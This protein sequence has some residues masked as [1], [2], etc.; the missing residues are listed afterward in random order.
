MTNTMRAYHNDP[1]LKARL[2]AEMAGHREADRL[3]Q[4][5]YFEQ[6]NG[7]WKGCAVGCLLQDPDGGHAR[8]ETEFGLPRVLAHLE[9]GI[10][11]ALPKDE[12][13][14][15]PERFLAAIP[16]GADLSLVW[17]R[18]A[19]WLLADLEHG[20]RQFADA[21]GQGAIN[22]VV[23]VYR[24]TI[25]GNT[26][27]GAAEAAARA[28]EAAAEATA[29]AAARAA[30]AAARAAEAA[31]WATARA[32]AWAAGAAARVAAGPAEARRL[33]A[34]K[35]IALLERA[36]TGLR[37]AAGVSTNQQTNEPS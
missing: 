12:A 22:G 15:W 3:V 16:V 7:D 25:A 33:Q 9:D 34:D 26:P 2:L 23:E 5:V 24:Q 13:Q 4:G 21:R 1:A 18:F 14:S 28:A 20:V 11:E 10:F 6:T 17:P 37:G 36:P 19:V 29:R 8:Y 35:L 30:E 31:A 27:T 32:A